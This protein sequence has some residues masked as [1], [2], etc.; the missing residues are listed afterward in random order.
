MKQTIFILTIFL[1]SLGAF[2]QTTATNFTCNDCAGVSH[3][4]FTELGSGKVIVLCWV[5]PCS[6]CIP[7]TLTTYNVVHSFD[8]TYPGRVKI[9]IVDDYANTSCT[10]L[11]GWCNSNGFPNSTK[12][13]N[14]A[15]K[16]SDYGASGM[17]KVVVVGNYTHNVYYNAVN[18]VNATSLSNAITLALHDFS[19]GIEEPTSLG[20]GTIKSYPNPVSEQVTFTFSLEKAKTFSLTIFNSLAL[21]EIKSKRYEFASGKQSLSINTSELK[22]GIYFARFQTDAGIQNVKF[23]VSR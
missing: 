1:A 17:P 6:S 16:M 12:F 15:I 5:M 3:D 20:L 10:S 23:V 9:Y 22:N 7:G 14:A 4:L 2:S 13:S 18:T 11:N 8:L 19:V 21:Q